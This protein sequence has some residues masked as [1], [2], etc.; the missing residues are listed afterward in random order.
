[1]AEDNRPV[2]PLRA[3]LAERLRQL[4]EATAADP[5]A[6]APLLFALQLSQALEAGSPRLDAVAELVRE[7]SAEAFE[8]RAERLG[9][10][11]GDC[12]PG[13]LH[14]RLTHL[15]TT[16]AEAGDFDAYAR[17]IHR[18]PFG[19][20][21]TAHPTFALNHPLSQALT[22]LATGRDAGGA[23][24][25]AEGRAERL[26]LARELPP[27]PPDDLTLETEHRWSLQA[28][29]NLHAALEEV[30]GAALDVARTR[31]PQRWGEL[32]P[33]LMTVA[34]WVGFDQDGRTD[35]TWQVSLGKRLELKLSALRRRAETLARLGEG[36][37]A[38]AGWAEAVGAALHLVTRARDVTQA[39]LDALRAADADPAALPAFARAMVE[40]RRAALVGAPPLLRRLDDALGAAPDDARRRQLL[41]LRAG[42]ATEG[43]SLARIHVRL[44]SGQLHNAVRREIALDG[45]PTD[46][47]NRRTY[48]AAIEALIADARPVD[49]SYGDLL[50]EPASARR[51]MMT[52]AQMRK[53]VDASTPV[54]FLIAETEAGFTLLTALYLAR[55]FGVED[56]VEI[57][58][59]FET[60]EALDRGEKIVEE[61]LRSRAFRDY[62]QRQGRLA[63]E[64]GFSDSGR[65][66]GQLAATFRIERLRFRLAERLAAHG[67]GGLEVVFFNTHGESVGRGGHP[68]SLVDRFRYAAPPRSRL[69]FAR[70]G[71]SVKEEDAFQGGEGYLPLLTPV[72]ALATVTAA[73]ESVLL[74]DPE[75]QGDPIYDDPDFASEFFA[76]LEQQ[77][78]SLVADP[79]YAA[80]VGVFGTHLLPKTGSRP[81]QRQAGDGGRPARLASVREL[82]AIP[83]NGVLQQ[84]GYLANSLFGL[85][86]AAAKDRETFERMRATSPRFRR[87]LALAEAAARASRADVLS[88]YARTLDPSLWLA[89]AGA[90]DEPGYDLAVAAVVERTEL[91]EAL[92]RVLRRLRAEDVRLRAA[93][94]DTRQGERLELLHA[95]RLA[96]IQ[97]NDRLVARI[98]DFN[99]RGAVT[100]AVVQEQ[101]VRLDAP[102]AL[103]RLVDYFPARDEAADPADYGE[104]TTYAQAG[105]HG[106]RTEHTE[107]FEPLRRIQTLLLE[108]SG[109]V[110][111]EIGACG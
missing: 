10:Y 58:P 37:D 83:N 5:L 36:K 63:I 104:P 70:I 101:L 20:V 3:E 82:R 54:R 41:V 81:V 69:E 61:A 21:L 108:I 7:L 11:L 45:A 99:P 74:P 17:A 95:L 1:M 64:F 32:A 44:N 43:V 25:T 85:G 77:F 89:R 56:H 80:L 93:G 98:P 40:G 48:F 34:T 60:Q 55:L 14:A 8:A 62:L 27:S 16:L 71:A 39:Q 2:V 52:V 79:D 96:L 84:L 31:W 59:L 110:T 94:V 72:A 97:F 91:C 53:H 65:F 86:R 33:R 87:A 106:Y 47:A 68:G 66:I 51:L 111:H 9:R 29:E 57:S 102:A 78:A 76:T 6:N 73:L 24:L 26:R 18:A 88:A 30:Y 35:I 13:P 4:T 15:F 107:V 12:D 49:I 103:E 28:L 75:A 46:P 109:A 92:E 42:V 105:A 100:L 23:P 19:V 67:L 38:E 90:A 22:E 50:A